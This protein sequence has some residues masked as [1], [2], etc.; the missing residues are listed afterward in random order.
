MV[1]RLPRPFQPARAP[2]RQLPDARRAAP[3]HPE[4]R[5]AHAMGDTTLN[6]PSIGLAHARALE[7]LRI[8][9]HA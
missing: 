9:L 3:L 7:L 5:R 1:L 2:N 8:E 6:R 4:L